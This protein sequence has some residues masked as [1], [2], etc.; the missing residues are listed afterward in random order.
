MSQILK[1]GIYNIIFG[2]IGQLITLSLGIVIPRLF[3]VHLGSAANGL[4]SSIGQIL[5][6]LVLLEAGLGAASVQ[7]LYKPIVKEDRETINAILSSTHKYFKSTGLIYALVV[8]VLSLLYPLAVDDFPYFVTFTVVILSGIPGVVNYYY[9]GKFKV[10]LQAE[11]KSY[12]INN[13][14]TLVYVLSS[15]IKI[16]IVSL[17][18]GIISIQVSFCIISIIQLL[19]YYIIF[20]RKYK[21]VN[22]H[23]PNNDIY[24]K[25]RTS[26]LIHQI[27]SLVLTNGPV[28]ILTFFAGLKTVSVFVIYSMIFDVISTTLLTISNGI[29]HI[30]ANL[31]HKNKDLFV[32]AYDLYE[33][34]F[35]CISGS[36][37]ATAFLFIPSFIQLYTSGVSDTLYNVPY[38][39]LVFTIFKFLACTRTPSLNIVNV[40]GNFKETQNSAVIEAALSIIASILFVLMFGIVGVIIG[41]ILALAYRVC[42]LLLYTNTKILNRNIFIPFIYI[43]FTGCGFLLITH[44]FQNENVYNSYF[45]LVIHAI[46]YTIIILPVS[47]ILS[48]TINTLM[49]KSFYVLLKLRFTNNNN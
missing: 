3:I 1:K 49:T 16:L 22:F 40:V 30:F 19:I 14:T 38:L 18:L 24:L 8:I 39:A 5:S 41:N 11:G 48:F 46:K 44:L 35:I 36:L 27:S 34:L 15:S 23:K 28:I 31:Y 9:T 37:L 45:E 7:A 12:I 32:F 29:S 43:L 6:Y 21:W 42:Y 20:A 4:L 47:T 25:K 10:L 13:I 17:G 26:V 33:C 2:A